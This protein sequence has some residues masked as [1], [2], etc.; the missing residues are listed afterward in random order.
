[1]QDLDLVKKD[2]HRHASAGGG[3][4]GAAGG[5]GCAGRT[6]AENSSGRP[7]LAS[8]RHIALCAH[9]KQVDYS[10]HAMSEDASS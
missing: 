7:M 5:A 10:A 8:T 1:M 9:Y 2:L 6:D 3:R 4:A